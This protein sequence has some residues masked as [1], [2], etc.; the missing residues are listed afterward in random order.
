MLIVCQRLAPRLVAASSI[1]VSRSSS[2]GCT[3]RTM[4]GRPMKTSASSTPSGVKATLIPND[5][6][7]RPTQPLPAHSAVS[8]MPA[9]AVGSAKGRSTSESTI[10]LPGKL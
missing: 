7:I 10:F 8:A 2:T 6:T 3:V 4:K 1:S 9:T 5:S